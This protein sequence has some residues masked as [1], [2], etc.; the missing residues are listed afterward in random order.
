MR[1]GEREIKSGF[2]GFPSIGLGV[3]M[4]RLTITKNTC[5]RNL[6]L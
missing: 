3:V 2:Y 4:E 5:K 6:I 1:E